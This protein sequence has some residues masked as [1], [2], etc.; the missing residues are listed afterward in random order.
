MKTF[1]LHW[2]DGAVELAHGDTISQAFMLSGYGAGA[3]SALDYYTDLNEVKREVKARVSRKGVS[4]TVLKID[5]QNERFHYLVRFE[6][7]TLA[8]CSARELKDEVSA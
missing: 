3:L 5:D 2:S 6:D 7:G 1:E 8:W 4:G